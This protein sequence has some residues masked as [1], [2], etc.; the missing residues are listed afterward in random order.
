MQRKTT[1]I[2]EILKI[3]FLPVWEFL[4][5]LYLELQK[6]EVIKMFFN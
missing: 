6:L 3:E 1:K 2:E 5:Q 4:Q